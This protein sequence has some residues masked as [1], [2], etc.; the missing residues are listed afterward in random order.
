M[1]PDHGRLVIQTRGQEQY[2]MPISRK[3]A[4]SRYDKMLVSG[5]LPASTR[6]LEIQHPQGKPR[7]RTKMETMVL[8]IT[9]TLT[10]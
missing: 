5:P 10:M 1:G 3:K 9:R 7:L 4:L 2:K 8:E 6:F